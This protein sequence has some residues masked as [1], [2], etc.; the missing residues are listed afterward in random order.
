[1]YLYTTLLYDTCSDVCVTTIY[2][3]MEYMLTYM[4]LENQGK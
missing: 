1:M 3:E 2:D 4:P